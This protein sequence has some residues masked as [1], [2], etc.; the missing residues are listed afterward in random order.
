MTAQ[1]LEALALAESARL[2]QARVAR[3]IREGGPLVAVEALTHP[4]ET[5]GAMRLKRVLRAVPRYGSH[6]IGRLLADAGIPSGRLDRRLRELTERERQAI[7]AGLV[8]FHDRRAERL[9]A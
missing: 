6:R 1:H 3:A 8:A 4:D 9:A 7:A 2:A 5:T